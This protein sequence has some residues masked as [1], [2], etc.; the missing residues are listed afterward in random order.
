MQVRDTVVSPACFH[1]GSTPRLDAT[2]S[3]NPSDF[4]A[5]TSRPLSQY[6]QA[7]SNDITSADTAA[8]ENTRWSCAMDCWPSAPSER[9]T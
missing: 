9:A 7:I 5:G 1:R 4:V 8:I 2:V 6:L 3:Q